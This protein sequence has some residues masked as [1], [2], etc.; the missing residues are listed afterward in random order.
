MDIIPF[1]VISM[2]NPLSIHFPV[3]QVFEKVCE[4]YEN[5]LKMFYVLS[6]NINL[7]FSHFL[8]YTFYEAF[9]VNFSYLV[10]GF[11]QHI[12]KC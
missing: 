6:A 12:E 10:E 3:P 2:T 11:N 7:R 1:S 4:Y 5:T 9:I 8:S